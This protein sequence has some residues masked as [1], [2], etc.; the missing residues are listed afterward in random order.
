MGYV[1][2]SRENFSNLLICV[3]FF[4]SMKEKFKLRYEEVYAMIESEI[5]EV[6]NNIT[7][8]KINFVGERLA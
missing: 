2:D 3:L 6:G 1:G 4:R 7:Q 8:K 5:Q